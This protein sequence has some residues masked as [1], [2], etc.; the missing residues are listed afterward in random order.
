[1]LNIQSMNPSASSSV[2]WKVNDLQSMIVDERSKGHMLPFIALTETW[3]KSYMSDAQIRIP[4]YIVSRC[5]RDKRVGGGVMLYSHE[6]LPISECNTFDD[7]TCQALFCRFDTVKMCVAVI[8]RP[9]NAPSSS[10][11]SITTFL[12][13]NI[14]SVD[15]DSYQLCLSGDFNLPNIDWESELIDHTGSSDMLQSAEAIQ[16]LMNEHFLNQ[17]VKIPTRGTNILDLFLTNDH[18]LVTNVAST[19][20][21][22]SDHNMVE[23]MISSNPL[24]PGEDRL[25]KFDE[26]SFRSMDFQKADFEE[27]RKEISSV[28]WESLRLNCSYEEFP[29]LFT[30]KLLQICKSLVPIKKVSTGRPKVL[31]ALRRKK[32]RLQTRLNALMGTQSSNPSHIQSVKNQLALLCYEMK[33]A[34]NKKLQRQES[35]AVEKIKSNPKFFYSYAKSLSK[36]KSSIS[37]LFNSREEIMTD[38]KLIANTLQDQFSSVYSDPASPDIKFPDF[39]SPRISKPFSDWDLTISDDD[40]LGAIKQ[41]QND[42]ACGPD[43]IPVILLKN[44]SEELCVPIK[45]IWTESYSLGTVPKFYKLSH[46]APLFKKGDRARA[47]NYRPVSLTSH[48]MKV[49]ERILRKSMVEFLDHNDILCSNQHGFRSGRSCLTQL[50][51]HFDEIMSGLT[52][53]KDTDA[54][55]L[56]YAKAFDK[57]D[58]RLLLAKL[59][60]YGFNDKLVKWVESF[61]T[62]R[63]QKVLVDGHASYL[64]AILS[65]VPQGT[66]LGPLLFI[67]FINDMEQCVQSSTIRFFADDTRLSKQISSEA[68]VQD[69]QNDL[70]KVIAWAKQNNMELHEDKF[71]VMVHLYRPSFTLYELPFTCELMAYTIS[72]G[73]TIHPTNGLKDLGVIVSSDMSWSPHVNTI[74][75]RA[76]TVAAWVLSAFMTRDKMTMLTLYKSLVRSHLEYCCPLWNPDKL[77]DIQQLEGVQRTFTSKISGVKHLDYWSRL[78]ALHLMSLQRRRERYIILQ[79]WKILH[80]LCPND[81]NIQFSDPSRHGIKAKL[82]KLN[83]SSSQRHQSIYDNSFAVIGPRLWNTIP[84]N[85]PQ[86]ADLEEFK[87]KLTDHLNTIPDKPPVSGYSCANGNSLLEWYNNKAEAQL[88]GR[89]ESL[90]TQ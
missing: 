56:D 84:S 31:N 19:V 38:P 78:K 9:P 55:Y 16:L 40:I 85:L 58:H 71:E 39:P 41:I 49:Y 28:D 5:D 1:M 65:G 29:A 36:V 45:M 66:V 32:R 3:L 48:I 88:L 70:N 12:K 42:S 82:P 2:K 80:G 34:F 54:I 26:N 51:S 81:I 89:S 52:N 13:T 46:V 53:Q 7:G 23:I 8:Y 47:G 43:G 6:N 57:V 21:D 14:A 17:Y 77:S 27:I 60:R 11:K 75:S 44:C 83:R 76:R 10:F 59:Y 4:G 22:L 64:A 68:D 72:T 15:D 30:E 33:E 50:L 24:V 69:L 74:T 20:T 37:M 61:L 86:I 90:M 63:F 87:F 67:L 79:M 18:H 73:D 35:G 25:P 62:G